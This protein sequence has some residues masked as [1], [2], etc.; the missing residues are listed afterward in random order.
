MT[1]MI[2]NAH[3]SLIPSLPPSLPSSLLQG[4]FP[5]D[6]PCYIGTYWGPVSSPGA[7]ETVESADMY[8]L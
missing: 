3:L 5:E 1:N 8:I 2:P 7:G 6:H 4:M